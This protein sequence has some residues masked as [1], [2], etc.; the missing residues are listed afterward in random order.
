MRGLICLF[1]EVTGPEK[2]LHSGSD[3]GSFTEPMN[4][5]V[6]VLSNLVDS[7][8]MI[9]VPGFYDDVKP[10]DREEEALY[11]GLT[12]KLSEYKVWTFE[13]ALE[14]LLVSACVGHLRR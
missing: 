12:F 7:N 13:L 10:L 5:L 1:L 6:A 4:N 11:E 9:L 8:N 3:G 2:N 14:S